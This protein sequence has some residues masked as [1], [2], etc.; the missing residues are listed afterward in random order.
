MP[1]DITIVSKL[2]NEFTI[3]LRHFFT[4]DYKTYSW[5]SILLSVNNH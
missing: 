3:F 5:Q 2:D 1:I 4:F